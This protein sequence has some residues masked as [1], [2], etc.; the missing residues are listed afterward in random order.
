[1]RPQLFSLT[2][3]KMMMMAMKMELKVQA[4]SQIA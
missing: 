2:K 1:M 4:V 3:M